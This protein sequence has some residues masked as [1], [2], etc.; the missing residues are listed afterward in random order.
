MIGSI[1]GDIAGAPYE[2]DRLTVDRPD[3][4]P[5]FLDQLSKFTD[6][7]NLTIAVADAI[8]SQTCF[9]DKILEWYK[10]NP[11]LGYGSGFKKWAEN[12]GIVINDSYA[13][14]GVMRVSPITLFALA[15]Q[16]PN[17]EG[18]MVN[19][20]FSSKLMWAMDMGYA[21]SY[22]THNT[23]E[24]RR[25]VGALITAS[26]MAG[27]RLADGSRVYTKKQ[28]HETIELLFDYNLNT[29]V[30]IIR[31]WGDKRNIRC[32]ITVPQALICFLES[33]DFEHCIRLSVYS[34]G[35]VDTV[36]AMA[37]GIAEQWYGVE[38]ISPDIL[39]ETKARLQP[40][41]IDI[42]NKSYAHVGKTLNW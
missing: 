40:E 33:L 15:L 35:D 17:R 1:I 32:N 42:V 16:E 31:N 6:D 22:F 34:K 41:M 38:S 39:A 26:M 8:L 20:P 7:T 14:G 5:F 36:A 10:K 29:T 37:G 23:G 13:N 9:R 21:S 11:D 28:I 4:R 27:Q 3:Y 12:G 19:E 25:G 24:A 30:S 18:K 2:G